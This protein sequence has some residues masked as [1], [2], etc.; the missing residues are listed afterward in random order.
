MLKWDTENYSNG[1]KT[2]TVR[3]GKYHILAGL[4]KIVGTKRYQAEI[5]I[6]NMETDKG[7]TKKL[8]I[9]SNNFPYTWFEEVKKSIENKIVIVSGY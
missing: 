5:L 8:E 9:T 2:C 1:E 6:R 7:K 3:I 4:Y